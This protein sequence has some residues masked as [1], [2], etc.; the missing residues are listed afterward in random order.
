[1]AKKQFKR[2]KSYRPERIKRSHRRPKQDVP[3]IPLLVEGGG[4]L[5]G[6]AEAVKGNISGGAVIAGAG[7]I[8]GYVLEKVGNNT[9]IG[10][11]KFKTKKHS[12]SII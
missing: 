1:M 3:A 4:V 8:G 6:A 11:L 5:L 7:L 12:V 9:M 10:K 2:R